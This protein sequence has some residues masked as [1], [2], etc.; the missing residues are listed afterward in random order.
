M[1]SLRPQDLV[2][3][4]F[5]EYLLHRQ[6][7]VAVQ[8]LIRL[9]APF[10]L[11]AGAVRTVLS[12]MVQKGWL[13]SSRRGVYG[14]S[15]K[16]RRLLEAGEAKI[17]HP[18][19]DEPW[20]GQWYVLSYSIPEDRRQVRDRLRDRL[21]WLGFGSLGNGLWISPHDVGDEVEELARAMKLTKRLVSFRGAAVG[22]TRTED[23]VST[24]W[25]LPAINRRYERFIGDWADEYLRCREAL[26]AGRVSTEACFGLRFRLIHEYREFPLLDPYLPRTMLPSD[27]GGECAA[28]LFRV[29]HDMLVEPADRWVDSVLA[30]SGLAVRR[31][32][33][34]LA[35]A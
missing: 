32:R 34:V 29:F 33:A 15:A 12:R 28:H 1:P 31:R 11:S 7:P 3:T 2:F 35:H 18:A 16:G 25:D 27:W 10:D 4:L 17:F 5:G 23:L 13:T 26:P 19:W 14:L 9:L 24:C 21:A 6:G 8:S 20:D 22:F 30:E